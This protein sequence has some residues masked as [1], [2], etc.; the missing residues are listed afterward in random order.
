M[1]LPFLTLTATLMVVLAAV[2][3]NGF[4]PTASGFQMRKCTVDL[5]CSQTPGLNPSNQL[6]LSHPAL[7]NLGLNPS[8]Q[9]Y[10]NPSVQLRLNL[11]FANLMTKEWGPNS[12]RYFLQHRLLTRLSALLL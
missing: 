2:T 10:L 7:L 3:A 4:T 5:Q 11:F 8:N 12:L 6:Y 9:L 1:S